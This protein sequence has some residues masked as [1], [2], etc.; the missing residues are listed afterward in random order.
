MSD[1]SFEHFD[2][3]FEL[4]N[5]DENGRPIRPRK[6]P[7]RKPNP[8][9]PAQ[10]KA[11]NRA[12][13]RAFRERKRR[14]MREAESTVMQCIFARDQALRELR[15]LKRRVEELQFEANYLKGYALT[16]KMAC[17]A[18][19]VQV[20]KFWDTGA[21]DE[22]GSDELTFSKT[23][24]VPQ[25]LEVFLDSKMNIISI[26]QHASLLQQSLQNESSAMNDK[27]L[28]PS[29]ILSC[30]S[31][32]ASSSYLV[33]QD[34]F[35]HSPLSSSSSSTAASPGAF[36]YA[37]DFDNASHATS[38]HITGDN[39]FDNDTLSAIAPQLASHLE[40]PFFQQLLNTDLVG[41]HHQQ[42]CTT[43]HAPSTSNFPSSEHQSNTPSPRPN[44]I[45]QQSPVQQ[46]DELMI[47]AKTGLIRSVTEFV[48][49]AGAD[50]SSS[51]WSHSNS[52]DKKIF[53]PMT[54]V[55]AIQQMRAVKNLDSNAKAL[56]TPTELQRMIRHDTR[57]DVVPGAALR[58]HMILF[59][60]F[61]D[62]NELFGYLAESS[63][64]LGGELGNTD[65]WFVPPNFFKKY[66][67]LCPNHKHKRMDNTAEIM[68]TLGKK[69]ID[70]MAQR[71]QMYIERERYADYF[72]EPATQEQA[73]QVQQVVDE[74]FLHKDDQQHLDDIYQQE[75]CIEMFAI[76]ED[77][78]KML[79]QSASSIPRL[80]HGQLD[81]L[82]S[83]LPLDQF[84]TMINNATIPQTFSA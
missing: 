46:E 23:K 56:F 61:Y 4:G 34:G 54:P 80:D 67:F 22:I 26:D 55:D 3:E 59:Q 5:L 77:D 17:V 12:A 79:D 66:W 44:N 33:E 50:D 19:Q 83:D 37:S 10:R 13:Q 15:R 48:D 20:P 18:N 52:N 31:P 71:K 28:P 82:D 47:D 51:S 72:P 40:T 57:I 78:D 16:L 42:P 58:D 11:Q 60:D 69:M 36:S 65:S 9:S 62:A 30:S 14:E 29:S 81:L 63:V 25:Q 8:P 1:L 2:P 64:F 24:G 21:T 39:E 27:D 84:M 68:V 49:T 53:P 73:E 75:Q 76:E 32:A 41:V 38:Y 45:K 7:G 43:H 6:K 35:P 74:E 70:L